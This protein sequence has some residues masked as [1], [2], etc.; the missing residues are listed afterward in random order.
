MNTREKIT[1]VC[2]LRQNQTHYA[3]EIQIVCL[4]NSRV[5]ATMDTN[6]NR[7][8]V[9]MHAPQSVIHHFSEVWTANTNV[10]NQ[11]K[12]KGQRI[13]H[14]EQ[15]LIGGAWPGGC[16]AAHLLVQAALVREPLVAVRYPAGSAISWQ[17]D[18]HIVGF[19][20][21]ASASLEGQAFYKLTLTSWYLRLLFVIRAFLNYWTTG[22]ILQ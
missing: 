11:L 2:N 7:P 19:L 1:C 20:T 10:V 21:W 4:V 14:Q 9:E 6:S 16:L 5:Y 13:A 12:D 15:T 3:S 22:H 18:I 8:R 17:N